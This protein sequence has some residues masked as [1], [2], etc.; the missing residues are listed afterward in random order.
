[1]KGEERRAKEERQ[2]HGEKRKESGMRER[3][4]AI[5]EARCSDL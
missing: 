3:I 4:S 1:M 2:K 5:F